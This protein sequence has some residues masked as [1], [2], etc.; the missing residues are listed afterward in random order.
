MP[1]ISTYAIDA[2]PS[3][4][5]KVIGTDVGNN[6]VTKNY[7]I[8]DIV[9]LASFSVYGNTGVAQTINNNDSLLLLGGVGIDSV[10]S[11]VDTVTFNHLDYG[12]PGT[13]A[14]PVS[15][16]VNTQGHI[17]GVVSG[18]A[19]GIMTSFDISGDTGANQTIYDDN[20]LSLVGGV[21]IDTA[22]SAPGTATFTLDISELPV[23]SSF[24]DADYFA[25]TSGTNQHKI[26][27]GDVPV[28]SF[29]AATVNLDMGTNKIISLVDPTVATDAATKSYVDTTFAGSGALIF[30]GGYDATGAPPTG[31]GVLTGFTYSVTVAG[32]GAGFWSTALAVG[33]VIISNQNNPTLE[34]QWTAVNNNVSLATAAVAGIASFPSAGGLSVLSGAVSLS[35]QTSNG[36]FGDAANSAT[37]AVNGKGVVIGASQNPI[38]ITASQ[39]TDFCNA[40]TLCATSINLG[41]ANLTQSDSTRTYDVNSGAI[42]FQNGVTPLLGI[43]SSKVS[44]GHTVPLQLLDAAGSEYVGFKA[45][46]AVTSSYT[47][48]L[49]AAVGTAGQFLQTS[50]TGVLS[51]ATS[52][53]VNLSNSNLTQEA[54]NRTYSLGNQTMRFTGNTQANV[55]SLDGTSGNNSIKT[56]LEVPIR[57]L[58]GNVNYVGL[59]SPAIVSTS[60]TLT[61][62]TADGTVGQ[63]LKTDGAGQLAWVNPA[64]TDNLATSDLVQT[65]GARSYDI[66]NGVLIFGNAGGTTPL[67]SL[68]STAENAISIS[69]QATL[70]FEL[71]VLNGLYAGIKAPTSLTSS[72]TLTLPENDG[73]ANEVLQT[74]GSGVLSWVSQNDSTN[75]GTSDLVQTGTGNR[76]YLLG[77][78]GQSLSFVVPNFSAYPMLKLNVDNTVEFN[79]SI[80]LRV[81]TFTPSDTRYLTVKAAGSLAGAT[82]YSITL[83]GNIP[84]VNQQLSNLLNGELAWTDPASKVNLGTAPASATSTG[85]QGDV[86][87]TADYIY[88]CTATN[89]WKRVAIATW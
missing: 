37:L 41:N 7:T 13:Y 82:S 40:V 69:N 51:W 17:T 42:Q 4:G 48:I 33:D 6:N 28:T 39:V 30:Q 59:K 8:G 38:A 21:G 34:S 63:V 11:N 58:D 80:K 14:Y 56:G 5:D 25:V 76:S 16:S 75:L 2:S 64:S 78:A 9:G 87:W 52:T 61:L 27:P 26:D 49:P 71:S 54:E 53:S 32:N 57:F 47:L 23:S 67:F 22:I 1:K 89:T 43:S 50:A 74:D 45:P 31:A 79:G 24:T 86:V 12:T 15:I 20:T 10:A 72:Y 73:N 55:F 65:G 18:V 44:I 70:R 68:N 88:V 62:P 66:D 29:G 81:D 3:I 85:A 60:Y 83:P 36:T 84:T 46:T 77:T 35:N 19:P